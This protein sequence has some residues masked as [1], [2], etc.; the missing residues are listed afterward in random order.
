MLSSS[1][2]RGG[3]VFLSNVASRF[4]VLFGMRF[5]LPEGQWR[6]G[7]L[8]LFDD[9]SG[10]VGVLRSAT[11]V[12]VSAGALF[13]AKDA[14]RHTAALQLVLTMAQVPEWRSGLDELFRWIGDGLDEVGESVR[15]ETVA[16]LGTLSRAP[17]FQCSIGAAVDSIRTQLREGRTEQPEGASLVAV[18]PFL[19]SDFGDTLARWINVGLV[20]PKARGAGIWT[21]EDQNLAITW[22]GEMIA[23]PIGPLP[24]AMFASRD[25]GGFRSSLAR[26]GLTVAEWRLSWFRRDTETPLY[27]SR[28]PE[29]L[30]HALFKAGL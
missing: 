14:P 9:H 2:R 22:G 29:P 10:G 13:S 1:W 17:R 23:S 30:A 7:C 3:G 11:P 28:D 27:T 8:R 20:E 6:D 21:S 5:A 26:L 15:A 16:T 4:A 18:V 19:M 12:A 25:L 24:G